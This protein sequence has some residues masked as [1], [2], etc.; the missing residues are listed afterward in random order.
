MVSDDGMP[1]E[2][3][4]EDCGGSGRT[5]WED[6]FGNTVYRMCSGCGGTGK[7]PA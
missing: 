6:M 4:C 3:G 1:P 5:E 7:V 2:V